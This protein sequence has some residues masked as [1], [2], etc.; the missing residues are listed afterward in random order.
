MSQAPLAKRLLVA[1]ERLLVDFE[2][3]RIATAA[4]AIG[5]LGPQRG[6]RSGIGVDGVSHDLHTTTV[7][8]GPGT[9]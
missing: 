7:P 3:A 4:A 8:E 2:D 5:G 1:R 6:L 9:R